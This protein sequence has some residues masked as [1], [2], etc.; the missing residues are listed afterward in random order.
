MGMEP[1]PTLSPGDLPARWRERA[2]FLSDFGDANSARLWQT[3][4][5]ELD[6]A[7]RTLGEET[8][9]L[10]EAAA[11]SGYT[12]DHLG[13]LVRKGKIPS[14]G[15]KNAPRVRRSDLPIKKPGSPGRPATRQQRGAA[16]HREDITSITKKLSPR[17][18]QS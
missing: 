17:R 15:Q 16:A 8:L 10:V 3:A 2:Q 9:T 14:Y 6:E 1:N 13:S 4:A 12:A 7:L 18:K 11:V 5:A